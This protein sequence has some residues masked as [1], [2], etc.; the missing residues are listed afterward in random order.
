MTALISRQAGPLSGETAVPGDK[1]ISHRALILGALAVG[2]TRITG[3]LESDDVM[4]T[5]AAVAALGARAEGD[6]NGAWILYGRGVGGLSEP[7]GVLDMGNSGTAA[8]L[9]LGVAA[10]H[11]F[12]TTF[13]GDPSLSGRPMERVMEPLRRMGAQFTTRSGG[14]LPITVTGAQAPIPIAYALP[15]ASAQVKSAVLLAGLNT[16]GHTK[17]IEPEP[18]RDHTERMLGQFGAEV[19]VEDK[20]S[21]REITLVGQ[22]ELTGTAIAIPGDISSAAFPLVAGLLVPGSNV[23]LKGVGVNPLRMGLIETLHEMGARITIENRRQMAGE[24]VAD[25]IVEAS[26]L[27]GVTVPAARAP[28]MID[29]YP[30]LAVAAAAAQGATRLEGLGELRVKE[31]DRLA[32][33]AGGLAAAGIGVEAGETS[34][35]VRGAGGPPKGGARITVA[36]DHRMAMAFLVLGMVAEEPVEIDDAR[37]M[38]TSFPGFQ[39][40]MN[41]LGAALSPGNGG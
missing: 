8:R 9:L 34:L 17:V 12:T 22:P 18:T 15:V 24:P 7:S 30:I 32:A 36:L 31:S 33:I 25:I 20:A 21:G 11:S 13:T 38:D 35:T 10:T 1:S 4:R 19:T 2:E 5:A 14:C 39:E 28:S 23:T 40:L 27:H 16:P 6:G 3:L 26:S 37:P 41:G 29:E